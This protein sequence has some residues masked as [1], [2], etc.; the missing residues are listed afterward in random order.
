[1]NSPFDGVESR[2]SAT[3]G[4]LAIQTLLDQLLTNFNLVETSKNLP[5]LLAIRS[6]M[7]KLD[8]S[9]PWIASKLT[10]LDQLIFLVWGWGWNLLRTKNWVIPVKK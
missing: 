4:G 3:K 1:M 9:S 10:K 8:T 5:A 2:W 6:A 7:L